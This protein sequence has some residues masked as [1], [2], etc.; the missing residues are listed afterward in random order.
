MCSRPLNEFSRTF[1]GD[2]EL[3]DD[4]ENLIAALIEQIVG[5]E[6]GKGAIGVKLLPGPIKKDR[7]VVMIIQGFH[8]HLPNQFRQRVLM[9]HSY[10]HVPSIVVPPELRSR[11]LPF[12]E[13]A[14]F[15]HWLL[16]LRLLLNGAGS[17]AA[18]A[19]LLGMF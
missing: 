18:N 6:N 2:D 15:G 1:D 14:R 11:D 13:G 16:K 10:R 19:A 3:G 7:Q 17:A 9:V 5:A 12:F 8:S 4:G